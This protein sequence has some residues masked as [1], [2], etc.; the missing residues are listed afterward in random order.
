[1]GDA[2]SRFMALDV[3]T[4]KL[5]WDIRTRVPQSSALLTTAGGLVFAAM[6]DKLFSRV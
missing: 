4:W 2:Q 6:P 1:M 5:M 3:N